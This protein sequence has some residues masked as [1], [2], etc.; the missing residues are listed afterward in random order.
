[1]PGIG[2]EWY[3]KYGYHDCHKHDYIVINGYKVRP[4]RYYDKLCEEEFF[5]EIKK[6]RVENADEPIINYGEEMDRLWVEEEV[7][8]KKLERLIRNV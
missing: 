6:T 7:K 1:M 8:I 5:A 3:Q 2:Y 4:P